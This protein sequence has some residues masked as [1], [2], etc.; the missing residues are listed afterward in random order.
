MANFDVKAFA[1]NFLKKVETAVYGNDNPEARGNG[2]VDETELSV[3]NSMLEKENLEM[4]DKD[5]VRAFLDSRPPAQQM[6]RK[7]PA[8]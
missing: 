1:E 3:F 7:E 5:A 2:K 4:S 8:E 6:H